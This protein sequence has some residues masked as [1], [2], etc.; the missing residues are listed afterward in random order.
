MSLP[1]CRAAT[2]AFT[3]IELLVVLLVIAVLIGVSVPVSTMVMRSSRV[4][5]S[6][7][8][9]RH[10]A[11]A[12]LAH[13]RPAITAS[14][15]TV[16]RRFDLDGDGL[17]D[18]DPQADGALATLTALAPDDY[19]GAVIELQLDLPSWAVNAARQPIDRWR[20]PLRIGFA[21]GAYGGRDVGVWSAG[22]DGIDT[23]SGGD[24]LRSWE[25]V[26]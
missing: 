14:D 15:G 24:D 5:A 17:I 13:P 2:R 20:H 18:G 1:A 8:V 22:P 21:A 23:S 26:P 9:V 4:K 12:I 10:V 7:M 16:R 25:P 6:Q 11:A 19:R 3:L